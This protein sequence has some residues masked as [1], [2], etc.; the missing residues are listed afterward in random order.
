MQ[1]QET[2]FEKIPVSPEIYQRLP[3]PFNEKVAK[4]DGVIMGMLIVLVFSFAS[5]LWA[6]SMTVITLVVLIAGKFYIQNKV[7]RDEKYYVFGKKP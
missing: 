2:E 4:I 5:G 1:E 7:E 6:P 3:Y